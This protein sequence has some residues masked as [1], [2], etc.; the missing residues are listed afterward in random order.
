MSEI[1]END[2][3]NMATSIEN[4]LRSGRIDR[5]PEMLNK[6][7]RISKRLEEGIYQKFK[8]NPAVYFDLSTL[9]QKLMG[10][11]EDVK[12]IEET[13]NEIIA[14]EALLNLATI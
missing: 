7:S 12:Q 13:K 14:I 2:R 4:M 5:R 9:H 11:A 3:S 6:I 1:S 10:L 8:N